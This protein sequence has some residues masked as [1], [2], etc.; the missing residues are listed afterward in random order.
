VN[1]ALIH[2]ALGVDW[3]E[4]GEPTRPAIDRESETKPAIGFAVST[5]IALSHTTN[6]KLSQEAYQRWG[7][8]QTNFER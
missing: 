8:E 5:R 6:N 1:H 2:S 3:L 7:S 4:P